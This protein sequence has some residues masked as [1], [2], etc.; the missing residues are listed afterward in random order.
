MKPVEEAAVPPAQK[1]RQ[2][3]IQAMDAWDEAAADAAVAGLARTAG[4]NEIFELLYRYGARDFRSIGHKAIFVANGQRT[5]ELIGWRHAESVLRSMAYALLM[6]EGDSPTHRDFAADRPWRR[7]Q[8]LAGKIVSGWQEGKLDKNATV[9]LL[10]VLRQGSE[11]A[12]CDKVVELLNGGIAPQSLW[13]AVFCGAAELLLRQPGIIALHAVTTTNALHFAYQSSSDDQTR[14]LLLLQN[15]AF[16]PMFRETMK[17]RSGLR[18]SPIDGLRPTPLAS[19]GGKAVEEI[20]REISRDRTAAP[21]KALAYLQAKGSL[22]DFVG[23]ARRL[24]S[25]KGDDSH[26]YKF[27]SAVLED[28]FHVSDPWR[29]RFLAASMLQL[30]GSEGQDSELVNRTRAALQA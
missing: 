3:F 30:R 25:L 2:A 28:Y 20:F 17:G 4:A 13:D 27:S 5:L 10:A 23:A 16:L 29:D 12:V 8:G 18:D 14:R 26:D 7:N 22:N 11:E 19:S 24:V 9:G 1:A 21:G 15:A 6:H